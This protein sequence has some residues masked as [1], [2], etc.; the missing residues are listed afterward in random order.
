M[1]EENGL[2]EKIN[3]LEKNGFKYL[4]DRDVYC[5]FNARKC[6][7]LEFIED[8]TSLDIQNRINVRIPQNRDWVFYFNSPP[9]HQ[10]RND[11]KNEVRQHFRIF[12]KKKK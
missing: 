11:I 12:R 9:S 5:N 6:F 4:F 10:L 2:K 8:S 7:S 1:D 3:L